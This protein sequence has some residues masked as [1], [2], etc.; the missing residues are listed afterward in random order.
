[1][2]RAFIHAWRTN[3]EQQR[4][5]LELSKFLAKPWLPETLAETLGSVPA[6]LLKAARE[7]KLTPSMNF[8]GFHVDLEI[9]RLTVN[10]LGADRLIPMTDD[11]ELNSMAGEE[12]HQI[13][14]NPLRYR[15]DEK[16]AAGSTGYQKQIANM[17]RIGIKESEID[18]MFG[19][20]AREALQ[21]SPKAK[22]RTNEDANT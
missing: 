14:N 19:T 20:L 3:D 11:T 18:F 7:R 8:D 17:R 10:Y 16:V 5:A 6:T 15:D 9:C 2:P 21:Y 13:E 1:M 12:L 4:R 22:S